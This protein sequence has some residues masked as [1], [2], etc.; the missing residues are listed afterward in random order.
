M[1]SLFPSG[2]SV[3]AW[4]CSMFLFGGACWATPFVQIQEQVVHSGFTT[5]TYD[6]GQLS[7][8]VLG[9]HISLGA[10]V[11]DAIG[12][13][14]GSHITG[15]VLTAG[16]QAFMDAFTQDNISVT[17]L[18]LFTPVQVMFTDIMTSNQS[19]SGPGTAIAGNTLRLFLGSPLDLTLTNSNSAPHSGTQSISHTVTLLSGDVPL[20][21]DETLTT[22]AIANSISASAEADAVN[23]IFITVLTPGA[24]II[25]GSGVVYS[26]IVPEPSTLGVVLAGLGLLLLIARKRV[27]RQ[28]SSV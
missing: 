15:T 27:Q 25:S 6:S 16:G 17:G 22:H 18:P 13:I 1:R 14:N 7:Q 10:T 9:N 11:A 23:D 19:L 26:S 3:K 28:I 24:T 12:N 8:T 4:T 21:F 5:V 2:L 20:V